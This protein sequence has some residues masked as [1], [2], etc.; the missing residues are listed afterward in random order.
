MSFLKGAPPTDPSH[1]MSGVIQFWIH[2]S[3]ANTD[4]DRP[5][6][7]RIDEETLK[8]LV[9]PACSKRRIRDS[10][11]EMYS[12][13]EGGDLYISNGSVLS[14]KLHAAA[15]EVGVA[16]LDRAAEDEGEGEE[17][18]EEGKEEGQDPKAGKKVKKAKGK[19][20]GPT[21]E[22]ERKVLEKMFGTYFD[23]KQFGGV[24]TDLKHHSQVKGPWQL[25]FAESVD[26]IRSYKHPITRMAVQSEKE[27]ANNDRNATFGD[28][29]RVPFAL[30]TQEFW[31]SPA[32][33]KRNLVTPKDLERFW[34]AMA[35]MWEF[36]TSSKAVNMQQIVVFEEPSSLG[37]IHTHK[38][39]DTLTGVGPDGKRYIRLNDGVKEA[40]H[41]SDYILP[42]EQ[43]VSARVKA[44]APEVKVHLLV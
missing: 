41:I 44:L 17:G 31:Y 24:L 34:M 35:R 5:G 12:G 2:N 33:A 9:T 15:K 14:R 29:S 20:K 30:F 18:K 16:V 19:A 25:N 26:P 32:L 42:T 1:R 40:S 43:E 13:E 36:R 38:L 39:I 10:H 4:P 37:V 11:Y 3:T 7:Q 28:V 8:G 6:F 27:A 22:E 23:L 21:P